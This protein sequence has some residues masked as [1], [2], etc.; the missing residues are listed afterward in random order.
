MAR[1]ELLA[2]PRAATRPLFVRRP[3]LGLVLAAAGGV[4]FTVLAL[5]LRRTNRLNTWEEAACQSLHR[6]AVLHRPQMLLAMQLIAALGREII[7][8][9]TLPLGVYWLVKRRWRL[10]S[11]LWLGVLGGNV[12]FVVLTRRFNRLRPGFTDPFH[13]VPGPGFPSGHSL[14][15]VTFYGLLAYMW[16]PRLPAGPWRALSVAGATLLTLLVGFS[17]LYLGDHYLTDVLGGYGF[18]V[19]WSAL[20]ITLVEALGA[21]LSPSGPTSG[22]LD[23]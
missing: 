5:N 9:I 12:W 1:R 7:T 4:V 19:F 17:R 21:R 11:L 10:L 22:T 8:L 2:C 3:G 14:T 20:T 23:D 6:R 13:I 15:S 16:Q 18:G